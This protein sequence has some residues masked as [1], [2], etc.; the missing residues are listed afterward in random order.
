MRAAL[1]DDVLFKV[2]DNLRL[3]KLI[4]AGLV[5]RQWRAVMYTHPTFWR[6]MDLFSD[7]PAAVDCFLVRLHASKTGRIFVNIDLPED[8]PQIDLVLFS[9]RGHFHRLEN[10]AFRLPE[11]KARV[12]FDTLKRPAPVLTEL[13]ILFLNVYMTASPCLDKR[14]LYRN[15]EGLVAFPHDIFNGSAPSLRNVTLSNVMLPRKTVAAFRD[16]HGICLTA[17][18]CVPLPPH[19]LRKHFPAL[20]QVL[21]CGESIFVVEGQDGNYA[22]PAT[23]REL[24]IEGPFDTGSLKPIEAIIRRIPRISIFSPTKYDFNFLCDVNDGSSLHLRIS[25]GDIPQPQIY[26]DIVN[27]HS[28]FER[29]Y[30]EEVPREKEDRLHIPEILRAYEGEENWQDHVTE[31]SV[32]QRLWGN[33]NVSRWIPNLPNLRVL[34]VLLDGEG[35]FR[36]PSAKLNTPCLESVVLV[37]PL[38]THIL[39]AERVMEI[40]EKGLTFIPSDTRLELAEGVKVVGAVDN[41]ASVVKVSRPEP[42]PW[43]WT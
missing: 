4:R 38:R 16:V 1:P 21:L 23:F 13:S 17:H 15:V 14:F 43:I 3:R 26:I 29:R 34:V 36:L 9:L 2:F 33:E 7:S 40:L 25:Y 20:Q 39:P 35:P 37:T 11:K 10:A 8:S 41:V 30:V 24:I 6:D 27:A 5:C 28:R 22:F 12:L 42:P 31:L 18:S 19:L 32:S